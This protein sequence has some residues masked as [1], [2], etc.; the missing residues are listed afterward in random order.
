ME[1][2]T[3][4]M[5]DIQ[6][7]ICQN[8][9]SVLKETA[10]QFPEYSFSINEF[11]A[12]C[13]GL[14]YD[15]IDTADSYN[16]VIIIGCSCIKPDKKLP[17]NF[18]QIKY[19]RC[20]DFVAPPTLADSYIKRGYF[21]VTSSWI[22]DWKQKLEEWGVKQDIASAFFRDFS[23]G[24]LLL[25]TG[26]ID[27]L[28]DKI[29]AFETFSGR[30]VT[31][32][33]IGTDYA[34][35]NLSEILK[36]IQLKNKKNEIKELSASNAEHLMITEFIKT[37]LESNEIDDVVNSIKIF[38]KML[39]SGQIEISLTEEKYSNVVKNDDSFQIPLIH[40]GV[41]FGNIKVKEILYPQYIDHYASVAEL[42][43][44]YS[45]A[46]LHLIQTLK[47][48]E[49][50]NNHL[51]I[52]VQDEVAK[53]VH[54][55]RT[56]FNQMRFVE[57]GQMINS[58]THQWRQPLNSLGLILQ[59]LHRKSGYTELPSDKIDEYSDLGMNLVD[60]MT[61]TVNDFRT[62]FLP[63]KEKELFNLYN[64]I[65]RSI[66]LVNL[67]YLSH[68]IE[69]FLKCKLCE[70]NSKF[71]LIS[72]AK[73]ACDMKE[74]SCKGFIGEFQQILLNLFQNSLDSIEES[75]EKQGKITVCIEDSA[76]CLIIRYNDTG[77]GIPE[78]IL[79]KIF[80]PYFT[81][82]EKKMGTGIGL[83]MSKTMIED[84]FDGKITASNTAEGAEFLIYLPKVPS[85]NAVNTDN[86]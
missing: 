33:E 29:D 46:A 16:N 22:N 54:S 26:E 14:D 74:C 34:V 58:I 71:C 5:S 59:S 17:D 45:A 4:K 13:A 32:L 61:S 80:E 7:C 69:I 64:I 65:K 28:A 56:L 75:E 72:D 78:E 38:F 9:I 83:Y 60:H 50:S 6:L 1:I 21:L 3:L 43:S 76:D 37:V 55:E 85:E 20:V 77:P 73:T 10:K 35:K 84:H 27:E 81:T 79:D 82:K 23:S 41:C 57:M 39:F 15:S 52:L 86:N 31:V 49:E 44:R 53:R 48:V 70:I 24:I 40:S 18:T 47:K 11:S 25:D 30:S 63:N 12:S 8:Y 66:N 68:N 51:E 62:F 19:D 67:R 2:S 36:N 42:L